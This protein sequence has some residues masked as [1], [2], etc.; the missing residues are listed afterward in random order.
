MALANSR[1]SNHSFRTCVPTSGDLEREPWTRKVFF[2][3]TSP[4]TLLPFPIRASAVDADTQEHTPITLHSTAVVVPVGVF[5]SDTAIV[6]DQGFHGIWKRY[7]LGSAVD[8]HPG[9]VELV[10]KDAQGGTWVTAQVTRF[11]GSFAATHDGAAS[12]INAD[13]DRR[14]LRTAVAPSCSEDSTV[15]GGEKLSGFSEIHD[16]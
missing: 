7:H 10:P 12:G 13:S 6:I 11:V 15:V 4:L 3:S 16:L 1:G 14:H 5:A 2:A 8:L 9:A